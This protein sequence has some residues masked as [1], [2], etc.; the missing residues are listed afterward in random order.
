MDH[1]DEDISDLAMQSS[2]SEE[3]PPPVPSFSE[4]FRRDDLEHYHQVDLEQLR[5]FCLARNGLVSPEWRKLGWPK[6]VGAHLEIWK[7]A[8]KIPPLD[9]SK[10]TGVTGSPYLHH[11]SKDEIE[12]IKQVV[13]S[14]EWESAGILKDDSIVMPDYNPER[15]PKQSPEESSPSPKVERRVSFHLPEL[16]FSTKRQKD[17][18]TLRKV[19]IH[20]KRTNPNFA[21]TS[22]TCSAVAMVLSIVQS[23]SMSTLVVHQLVSFPWK[24][25]REWPRSNNAWELDDRWH[26]LFVLLAPDLLQHFESN[27]V[28]VLEG[29]IRYSWIPSWLSQ[30]MPKKDLLARIWDVLIPSKPD[31]IL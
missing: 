25:S 22:A 30:N 8:A 13:A 31:A 15:S 10:D 26:H 28:D 2:L 4:T 3:T 29:T 24:Y 23:S 9:N 14:C 18:K 1:S 7:A 5:A 6:L 16:A 20:L 19:L 17:R 21:I 27:G 12:Y 11:P